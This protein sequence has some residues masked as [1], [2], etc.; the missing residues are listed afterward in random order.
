MRHY[1][2]TGMALIT[3]ERLDNWMSKIESLSDSE[4]EKLVLSHIKK[5][6]KYVHICHKHSDTIESA[7]A[8][9]A[10]LCSIMEVLEEVL[11]A[12]SKRLN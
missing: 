5:Y 4:S 7:K 11:N 3:P 12:E 8:S 1:L 2:S 9:F 10:T 6:Q